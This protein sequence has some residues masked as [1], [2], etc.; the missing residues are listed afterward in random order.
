MCNC[1]GVNP[2][3]SGPSFQGFS[4]HIS[5]FSIMDT[6]TSTQADTTTGE[7]PRRKKK[8]K[9]EKKKGKRIG[10]QCR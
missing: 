1:Y 9:K 3:Q 2:T 4:E 5:F 10:K 7:N 6:T 8:D